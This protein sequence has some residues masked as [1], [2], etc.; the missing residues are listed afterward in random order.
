MSWYYVKDN[1]R[2]G[3]ISEDELKKLQRDGS[4]NSSSL[5]WKNGLDNW[6]K[7]GEVGILQEAQDDIPGI[8]PLVQDEF[9]W[10]NIGADN[11]IFT[12]KSGQDQSS[13][14]YGPYSVNQLKKFFEEKRISAKTLVFAVGMDN[15]KF[16]AETP[17]FKQISSENPPQIGESE[18]RLKYRR[19]FVARILFHNNS[20]I[21]EGICNDVS[22]SG[23]QILI[24]D[25]PGKVG[26]NISINVHPDNSEYSFSAKGKIVRF[27]DEMEGFSLR[28][29]KLNEEAKKS[30]KSYI[31]QS[32]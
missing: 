16:I 1:R 32:K 30:I 28:F 12:I 10:S 27:L 23:I 9:D 31:G 17:L 13:K 22:Q 24:P 5:V 21:F 25:F 20:T 26:D 29:S 11:R 7:L 4:I 18:R 14:E 19:P 8:P 2:M 3:P 6:K 15:W